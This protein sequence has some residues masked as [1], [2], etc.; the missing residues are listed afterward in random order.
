[1][2]MF[3]LYE[4]ELGSLAVR[5]LMTVRVPLEMHASVIYRVNYVLA[6]ALRPG[7]SHLICH[8]ENQIVFFRHVYL[9]SCSSTATILPKSQWLKQPGELHSHVT[10]CS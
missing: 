9:Q 5:I 2:Y 4:S 6:F 10:V 7:S 1:M 3:I 8:S